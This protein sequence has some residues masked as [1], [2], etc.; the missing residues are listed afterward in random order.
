MPTERKF[1]RF[2][3]TTKPPRT[4]EIPEGG[5]C[6]SAFVVLSK[7]KDPNQVLLGRLNKD[8]PWDHLGA[9]DG[10]R[11]ERISRGWMLPSS[12]LVL[13]ESPQDA[14]RRILKEQLHIPNQRFNEPKV[15][16]EVYGKPPHWDFEFVFLGERSEIEPVECW[17]D[18]EFVDVT[19]VRKADLARWH[20]D[21]LAHVGK[22][23]SDYLG[24]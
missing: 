17:K 16:C 13:H 3:K 10:E 18:L 15:F 14:A 5:F 8:A 4:N 12:H 2:H 19:K 22:F 24:E 6:L 23:V 21:V 1:A 11:A 9:L 20:E 7:Q